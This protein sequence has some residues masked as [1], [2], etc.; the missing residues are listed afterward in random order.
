MGN[1]SRWNLAGRGPGVD[2]LVWLQCPGFRADKESRSHLCSSYLG[3]TAPFRGADEYNHFFRANHVSIGRMIA[4]HAAF[5]VL[6]EQL[7]GKLTRSRPR[8]NRHRCKGLRPWPY[9][10]RAPEGWLSP[11]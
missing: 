6:G 4:H 9:S 1:R 3:V 5:G 2:S 10:A 11:V 7:P 8:K